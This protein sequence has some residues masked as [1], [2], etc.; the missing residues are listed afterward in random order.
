MCTLFQYKSLSVFERC[1]SGWD[2][3]MQLHIPHSTEWQ[4]KTFP[5]EYDWKN[6]KLLTKSVQNCFN[7]LAL[8]MRI[9]LILIPKISLYIGYDWFWLTWDC[10]MFGVTC[11]SSSLVSGTVAPMATNSI[12]SSPAIGNISPKVTF[13]N[14]G[15]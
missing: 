4:K 15:Q 7:R 10:D 14:Y 11:S 13:S 3:S 9:S 8:I 12:S 1:N 2:Q 6:I 5:L